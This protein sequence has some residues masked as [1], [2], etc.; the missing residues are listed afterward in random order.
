ML[1][2]VFI[3]SPISRAGSQFAT[4][5]ALL[6]GAP[7]SAGRIQRAG[8]L[9]ILQGL[10]RWAFG[11]G[12]TCVGHVYL[13]NN[14]VSEPVLRHEAVHARQWDRYGLLFPV[15]YFLAGRDAHT[16]R[17]EIEAGLQDGGYTRRVGHSSE[18]NEWS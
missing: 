12:G 4:V 15:L 6:Y 13:T 1:R 10:P 2:R 8:D 7:L 11:R 18:L 9:W 5:V 16:N 17:F 3:D 14:N